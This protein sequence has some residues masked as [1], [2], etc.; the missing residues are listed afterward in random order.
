M[1]VSPWEIGALLPNEGAWVPTRVMTGSG[2]RPRASVREVMAPDSQEPMALLLHSWGEWGS[3][4]VCFRGPQPVQKQSESGLRS[5]RVFLNHSS[6]S[7]A[8]PVS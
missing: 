7:Q 3:L 1:G 2:L 4:C 8:V 5:A 6:S